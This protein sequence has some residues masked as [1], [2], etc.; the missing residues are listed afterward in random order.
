MGPLSAEV[1]TNLISSVLELQTTS[2]HHIS[3]RTV[4]QNFMEWISMAKQLHAS[5][6]SICAIPSV[7]VVIYATRLGSNRN[8][9]SDVKNH[10]M[11][12]SR[13]G[14]YQGSPLPE[15]LVATVKFGGGMIFRPCSCA[16]SEVH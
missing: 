15:C 2:G 13:F 5:L 7:S 1:H 14:N 8:M 16:Q 4:L 3:P 6:R 12:E 11:A 10:I 9:L